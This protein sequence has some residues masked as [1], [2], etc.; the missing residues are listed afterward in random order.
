MPESDDPT[1]VATT[2]FLELSPFD[3]GQPESSELLAALVGAYSNPGRAKLLLERLEQGLSARVLWT[4]PMF[5]VWADIIERCV[6]LELLSRLVDEALKDDTVE[7]FHGKLNGLKERQ[8]VPRR[9]L[10]RLWDTRA[11][12]T[13]WLPLGVSTALVPSMAGASYLGTSAGPTPWFHALA[14]CAVGLMLAE[15]LRVVAPK[16]R[17][18][19]ALAIFVVVALGVFV[20]LDASSDDWGVKSVH[21]VVEANLSTVTGITPEVPNSGNV[22]RDRRTTKAFTFEFA[23]GTQEAFVV[24]THQALGGSSRHKLCREDD[25]LGK[26]TIR[27]NWVKEEQ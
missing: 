2:P 3:W 1:Q 8:V 17:Q 26:T 23:S 19:P 9:F 24:L 7:G 21:Y 10:A 6:K 18:G 27:P 16:H 15:F 14:A 22:F 12:G 25:V 11:G 4:Q 20:A 13:R 5:D